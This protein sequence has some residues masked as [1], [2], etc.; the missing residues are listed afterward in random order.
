S[1]GYDPAPIA[2]SPF[3]I[4][5]AWQTLLYRLSPLCSANLK[6]VLK[7]GSAEMSAALCASTACDRSESRAPAA[8]PMNSRIVSLGGA[9]PL[10]SDVVVLCFCN[11]QVQPFYGV[12]CGKDCALLPR[13]NVGYVFPRQQD[14]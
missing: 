8:K 9:R 7:V 11:T 4:W 14:P 13:R 10:G 5:Q 6:P 12:Q 3:G 2:P 1:E